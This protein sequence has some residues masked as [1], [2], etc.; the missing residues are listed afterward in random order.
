[1]EKQGRQDHSHGQSFAQCPAINET[2]NWTP[3]KLMGRGMIWPVQKVLPTS[4]NQLYSSQ[5][6]LMKPLE[7][8]GTLNPFTPKS[9]LIDFTLPNARQFY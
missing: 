8:H 7:L 6:H 1:M 9:D 5:K 4:Q 2:L 3:G